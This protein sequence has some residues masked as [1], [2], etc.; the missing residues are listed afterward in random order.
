MRGDKAN[1]GMKRQGKK[2][3]SAEAFDEMTERLQDLDAHA[4]SKMDFPKVSEEI[5]RRL[6]DN[7]Y[8]VVTQLGADGVIQYA[9]PSYKWVLG[10]EPEDVIGQSIFE[11]LHSENLEEAQTV[12]FQAVESQT[13][14]GPL[15]FR[16][17]HADGHYLWMEC[18]C[19]VFKDE[20]DEFA[21]AVLSSRDI[22]QRKEM[23][24]ALR[25]SEHRYR[26]LAENA[27]DVIWV[28]NLNLEMTYI[29]P[30]VEKLRGFSVEEAL[31]QSIYEILTPDSAKF[32]DEFYKDILV[33]IES[34][35]PEQIE[36]K[37]L[38]LELEMMCK[39]G[40]RVWTETRMSFLLDGH[41]NL[42]GILG[43]TR[44]IA[45]RK[46]AENELNQLNAELEKRVQER[47][48]ELTNEITERER[49]EKA[50]RESEERYSLAV[51]GA[52]DG[53]WDWN[54][55]SGEI[56]FSPRWSSMLGF[57]ECEVKSSPEEWFERVHPEDLSKLQNAINLH[58][59]G[60]T[61]H[62]EC[63]YRIRHANDDYLWMLCRGLAVRNAD[64]QAYR[65]AGSQTDI[66]DRKW[67]EERLA[68]DALH[69]ALT[70]LPNRVLF[71]DRLRQRLEYAKRH[72]DE[73]F[74][75]LFMDLDR[76]K[77][78]ND[79]LGHSVGDTFLASIANH[80]RVS[81][82]PDDTVSRLGGDEFAIL[83]NRVSD[84]SDTI[85]V[86]ERILAQLKSTDMLRAVNR[87][88]T[89]SIGIALYTTDYIDP[90]ELLRD[91]DSAMYRAKAL[92]GGRYQ[93]FDA[94]M[95]ENAVALLQMEAD[96]KRAVENQEWQVYYQP[97]VSLENGEVVGVEALL[98]WMH[99]KRGMILPPDFV[100][101]AEETG[102]ITQIGNYVLHE[103]CAQVKA[104]R[105]GDYPK[106]WIAVNISGRQ[107]QDKN[108]IKVVEETLHTVGL[109]GDG[110]RVEITESV[111]MK[112]IV[113]SIN[114]LNELNKRGVSIS[115]DDFGNGY[116]SLNY[117]K[118]FPLKVLKI[119]RSFIRNNDN[120]KNAEAITSAIIFM[121][122]TLNLEVIAE[123]VETEEQLK[124]LKSQFCDAA[125]GFLFGQPMP[126]EEFGKLLHDKK[127]FME[128]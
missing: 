110:L 63:E 23:E 83:L 114:V 17:L 56:Y 102:L 8:D 57:E 109:S 48:T 62:F 106:L 9:S 28:R 16:Y 76:F 21:G 26:L 104:W 38:K 111:A 50:L 65:M 89:A 32:F 123:G 18:V 81:L 30:A 14:P 117:L 53:L 72:P 4:S 80:L 98:R 90:Q 107:F 113:H 35:S 44:D 97:I 36:D 86:A 27:S 78:I 55:K 91:A 41:G 15:E 126:A 124:F 82:R 74:A 47:T 118:Q 69:D 116:S 68:H 94:T 93:I 42:N 122:Q 87:S 13:R 22:T 51:R 58:L 88:S 119:D 73:L 24:I 121:G 10:I 3:Q 92:G 5:L 64:G 37:H 33:M 128:F 112:D 105:E 70:G 60:D 7:M 125:Q 100:T 19:S 127:N 84:V 59:N 43:V 29:S 77:V 1:T 40:S 99:P 120:D 2:D 31:G 39:D 66:T 54:L 96:L 75:V 6:T 25:E 103:A 49:T 52:N 34:L 11:R 46:Q 12:F 85:R 71:I 115:L 108:L 67:V 45:E 95:Y 101:V 61:S 20:R 79:S